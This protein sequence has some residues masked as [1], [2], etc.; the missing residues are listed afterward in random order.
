MSTAG[1]CWVTIWAEKI[2]DMLAYADPFQPPIQIDSDQTKK[3]FFL[4]FSVYFK[5]RGT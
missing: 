2:N 4:L 3:R 1:L 5:E